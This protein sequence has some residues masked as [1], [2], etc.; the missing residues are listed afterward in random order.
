MITVLQSCTQSFLFF[1]MLHSPM[2]PYRE[3]SPAGDHT[4]AQAYEATVRPLLAMKCYSCHGETKQKSGLDLR[5]LGGMLKGGDSGPAI[6]PG[7]ADQSP[8]FTMVN[9]REMPPRKLDKLTDVEIATLR[10]WIEAGAKTPEPII[11]T[12][13]PVV[14]PWSFRI[15]VSPSIPGE[16]PALSSVEPLSPN[17][18]W[19]STHLQAWYKADTLALNDFDPVDCW[20]DASGHGRDLQPTRGVKPTGIGQAPKFVR[21]VAGEKRPAVRFDG[22]SGLGSSPE[23]PIPVEGD[24]AYTIIVAATLRPRFGGY[25]FDAIVGFGDPAPPS[26]PGRPIAA[27]LLI[28]RTIGGAHQLLHAGSYGHDAKF[29]PGSFSPLYQRVRVL[30]LTKKP[31]GM[32][33]STHAFVDGKPF[34]ESPMS[35]PVSGSP[36]VPDLRHRAD[37]DIMMGQAINGLGGITGDVSEVIIFN[38]ALADERREGGSRSL[39]GTQAGSHRTCRSPAGLGRDLGRCL[40]GRGGERLTRRSSGQVAHRLLHP[41]QTSGEIADSGTSG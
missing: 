25:P 14:L 6:V 20:P 30:S 36:G 38:T 16:I 39:S 34:I 8:L 4:D 33:D 5:T 10:R 11:A 28:D 22:E 23:N 12:A 19:L 32:S 41:D 31:G 7:S 27:F 9:D 24:G 18:I 13:P 21:T 37:F 29:G 17:H 3:D 1:M 2:T 15:P 26:D 35:R 40:C